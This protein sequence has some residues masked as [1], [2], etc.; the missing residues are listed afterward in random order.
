MT[1]LNLINE[2]KNLSKICIFFKKKIQTLL[3]FLNQNI[4][5]YTKLDFET[6]SVQKYKN[7]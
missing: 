6:Q 2:H 3:S 1:C 5:I 7:N 4:Q